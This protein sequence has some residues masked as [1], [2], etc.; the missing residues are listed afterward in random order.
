M[1]W[2]VLTATPEI[3][4]RGLNNRPL[5]ELL[6]SVTDTTEDLQRTSG[7]ARS[8]STRSAVRQGRK[9]ELVETTSG[10]PCLEDTDGQFLPNPLDHPEMITPVSGTRKCSP[11]DKSDVVIRRAYIMGKLKD[12]I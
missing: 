7:A 11:P 3:G 5:L 10:W 4:P 9:I 8:L 6:R 12:E 1:T 2:W